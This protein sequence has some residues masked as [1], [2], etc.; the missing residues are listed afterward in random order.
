M[1]DKII[2]PIKKQHLTPLQLR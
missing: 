2:L 1:S